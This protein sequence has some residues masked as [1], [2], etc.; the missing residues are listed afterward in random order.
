V[1][2]VLMFVDTEQY[3]A[4]VAAMDDSERERAY[5]RVEQWFAHHA[6]KIK[7]YT[8]LKPPGPDPAV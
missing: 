8:Y 1:K 4:D 6:D 3:A 5:G 2:Y 7:G